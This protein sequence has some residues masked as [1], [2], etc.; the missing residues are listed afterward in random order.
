[1]NITKQ[2]LSEIAD[3]KLGKA[4]KV[5]IEDKGKSGNAYLIK[6]GDL[7]ENLKTDSLTQ[8]TVTDNDKKFFLKKGDILLRLRGP[9]F[10]AYIF[11]KEISETVIV[12]NQ[13]AIISA[14]NNLIEAYYLLWLLNSN[15]YRKYFY[16][17]IEGS[18][19]E[20]LSQHNLEEMTLEILP[21][22]KQRKIA[23]LQEKWISQKNNYKEKIELGDQ[24][25]NELCK[26]FQNNFL[27]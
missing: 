21:I 11:D 8:I 3:I 27:N 26:R 15:K 25:Y 7:C 20:K 6:V 23:H 16:T 1:M 24:Y 4:F 2:K 18:N 13:I 19:I 12:N 22:Q 14:N 5:A 10:T 9:I 17:R